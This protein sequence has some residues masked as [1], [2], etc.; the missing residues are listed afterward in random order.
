MWQ[1]RGPKMGFAYLLFT[2]VDHSVW[3]RWSQGRFAGECIAAFEKKNLF[4]I[5]QYLTQFEN[6]CCT[7]TLCI[8]FIMNG[9]KNGPKLT[10]ELNQPWTILYQNWWE[11]FLNWLCLLSYQCGHSSS[12]FPANMVFK[13]QLLSVTAVRTVGTCDHCIN[14]SLFMCWWCMLHA[15]RS[16]YKICFPAVPKRFWNRASVQSVVTRAQS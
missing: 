5:I 16:M 13:V 4:L 12:P 3:T 6:I 9:P 8:N 11:L 7:L 14:L 2:A 1:F 15:T 10:S